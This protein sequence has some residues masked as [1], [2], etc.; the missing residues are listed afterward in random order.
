MA[1]VKQSFDAVLNNRAAPTFQN[2]IAA[3]QKETLDERVMPI[4]GVHVSNLS[5]DQIRKLQGEWSPKL[6]AFYNELT[7]DPRYFARVKALYDRRDRL[8]LDE[9]QMRL[10]TRTY[11]S[12]VANGAMLNAEQKQELIR[13]ETELSQQFS[14]FQ[15]KVLADE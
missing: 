1:S 6:S 4:W 12:L 13:I 14:E 8:K 9:K 7:L 5:N 11:D 3:L 15:N 10:L 2:T